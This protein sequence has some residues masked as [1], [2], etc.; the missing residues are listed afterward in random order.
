MALGINPATGANVS[1]FGAGTNPTGGA[2]G[3]GLGDGLKQK[4]GASGLGLGLGIKPG[5]GANGSGLAFGMVLVDELTGS[6][7]GAG[8]QA[9]VSDLVTTGAEVGEGVSSGAS[10]FVS[11]TG[12]G[13]SSLSLASFPALDRAR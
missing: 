13:L 11:S 4:G 5:G 3:S 12:F 8:P 6:F 10:C 7:L 2:K 1:R 9:A